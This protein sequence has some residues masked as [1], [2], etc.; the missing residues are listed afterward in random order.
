ML[1]SMYKILYMSINLN[2]KIVTIKLNL[3]KCY[4]LINTGDSEYLCSRGGICCN[5]SIE[6]FNWLGKITSC[7]IKIL[8]QTI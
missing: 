3:I 8:F 7:F 2:I 4:R 6:E 5:H 1:A